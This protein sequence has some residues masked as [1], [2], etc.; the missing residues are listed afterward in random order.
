MLTPNGQSADK[1]DKIMLLA[2]W[3]EY[4]RTKFGND[5][6]FITAGMGKP[7]FR[8]NHFISQFMI[9]HW[10]EV[11]SKTLQSGN[12]NNSGESVALGYGDPQGD[13]DSRC[14]MA[15]ALSLWYGQEVKPNHVL[16]TTGGA[17]AIRVIL[18][19]LL[20]VNNDCPNFRIV[21]PFPYY[22]LYGALNDH[23]HPIQVMSSQG[24]RLTAKQLIE[25]VEHA[26]KLAEVDHG[27]PRALLLCEPNNPLG[28]TIQIEELEKIAVY[29]RKNSKLII[30][31]DEAYAEMCLTGNKNVSL[32]TIAPDL[33]DRVIFMRSATKALSAAG[34]RMAVL[35]AKN[36]YLMSK[37]LSKHISIC[38][39]SPR[40]L[41]AAYAATMLH[42][43]KEEHGAIV[44]FYRPKVE[45]IY[46]R[47]QEI[48]ASMPDESYKP[49]ATFYV[50][51][52]LS[53]LIG[54]KMPIGCE[55]AV[56]KTGQITNDEELVYSLLFQDR[57]M[58]SP[59]SYF[60]MDKKKGVVRITCSDTAATLLE[61]MKR[62]EN[63]LLIART[64]K[65]IILKDKVNLLLEKL[66][67]IS[68]EQYKL[69]YLKLEQ[70]NH[71]KPG[72][73]TALHVKNQNNAFQKLYSLITLYLNKSNDEEVKKAA[74]TIQSFFR[75][76][77]AKRS[78]KKMLQDS[79]KKWV[80]Y[81]DR[82]APK[83]GK[84]RTTLLTMTRAERL[85]YKSCIGLEKKELRAKL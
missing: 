49:E 17:A 74:I 83:A 22:S 15:S 16:F 13:L 81:V 19:T 21:T 70:I 71:L 5:P 63:R 39:H 68:F 79:D 11:S 7:T 64:H 2:I 12:G 69:M 28:T 30:I 10:S 1:I 61:M 67:D 4:L 27:E 58:L 59:F 18:E 72:L 23:L 50:L 40:S 46:K 32:F 45:L 8:L 73:P 62:I 37:F 42:F 78:Y 85:E 84:L 41:Q 65:N 47:L 14:K 36:E 54:E 60:G 6:L 77:Q 66:K 52:D 33:H 48:G 31:L 76:V 35:V 38:G 55:K 51:A 24:Y 43:S 20:E 56:G 44:N 53:D 82:V 29:L 26:L 3:A 80:S 34:E 9:N 75:G 57:V 25:S